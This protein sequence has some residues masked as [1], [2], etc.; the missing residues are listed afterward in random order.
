MCTFSHVYDKSFKL[1]LLEDIASVL[2]ME[3]G[4]LFGALSRLF[5]F[6]RPNDAL[7]APTGKS[8]KRRSDQYILLRL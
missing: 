7:A 8:W 5:V 4:R 3:E 1:F 6:H 2:L